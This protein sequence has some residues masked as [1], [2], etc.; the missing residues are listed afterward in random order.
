MDENENSNLPLVMSAA[1]VP[2]FF[3]I[4][5]LCVGLTVL[6]LYVVSNYG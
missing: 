4:T 3:I 2:A 6:M 1:L 5:M